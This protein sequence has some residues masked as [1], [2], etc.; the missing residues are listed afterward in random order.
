MEATTDQHYA[1][2]HY[3]VKRKPSAAYY[4]LAVVVILIGL[5]GAGIWIA[6]TALNVVDDVAGFSR[7]SVPGSVFVSVDTP[8]TMLV[9]YEGDASVTMRDLDLKVTGPQGQSVAVKTYDLHLQYEAPLGGLANAVASFQTEEPGQYQVA[10]AYANERGAELA[11]G[12]S[13]TKSV[14]TVVVGA[15]AIGLV[16]LAGAIA[17]IIVTYTR[18]SRFAG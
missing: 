1:P 6:T 16:T 7:N 14:V 4:W 3:S 10:T 9:F 18:R 15:I 13:F 11:V 2:A 12:P 8:H 17:L 5:A